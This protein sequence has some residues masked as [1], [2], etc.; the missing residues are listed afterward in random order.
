MAGGMIVARLGSVP[1]TLAGC[2]AALSGVTLLLFALLFRFLVVQ[3]AE[4][5][6]AP[7]RGWF[8]AAVGYGLLPAI[9][10]WKVFEG[11]C[12]PAAG[13]EVFPP[14]TGVPWVT[15][16][17]LWLP[18]RLEMVLALA[19]FL[20][21]TAWLMARKEAPMPGPDLFGTSLCV[22]AALRIMTDCFYARSL[23]IADGIH[24][25]RYG[26]CAVL[27]ISL[28]GWTVRR[29]R[30]TK[31]AGQTVMDW[32]SALIGTAGIVLCTEG[33]I[34]NLSEIGNLAVIAGCA[35]LLLTVT[36]LAGS[37]SRK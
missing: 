22:W 21:I 10:V 34:P 11:F 29:A 3:K 25:M 35:A 5:E 14:L 2:G 6:G 16:N 7:R 19:G 17:G 1:L 30:K 4:T 9:A 32:A 31:S 33:W 24:W 37:D 8:L 27:L 28:A 23:W 12:I 20:G 15:E 13:R 36:L 18:A 26:C